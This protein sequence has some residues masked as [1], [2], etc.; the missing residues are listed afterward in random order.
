VRVRTRALIVLVVTGAACGGS[1]NLHFQVSKDIPQQTINSSIAPCTIATLVPF[2]AAPLQVTFN[3]SQDFPQQKTDVNHI[4]SVKL[5]SLS[6][7]L[8]ASSPQQDWDFLDEV[9]IT[10]QASGLSDTLVASI[11]AASA[12]GVAIPAGAITLDLVP[13]G[14]NLAP[15]VKASGGFTLA[16]QAKGC[17]PSQDADFTGHTRFNVSARPL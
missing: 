6:L 4:T 11:G 1:P 14:A 2:L 16:A 13:A 9:D 15:F 7:T 12:S 10:A 3:Q 8:T 5:D 17:P